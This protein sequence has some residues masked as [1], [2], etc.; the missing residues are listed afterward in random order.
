MSASPLADV[1]RV[2]IVDDQ[3]VYRETARF[4]VEMTD[5]FEVVGV[6]ETGEQ[7]LESADLLQPELVLMD[8]NMPGIDGLEATRRLRRAQPA[9]TVIV[10]STLS[11]REYEP[12]AL[13]AGA[14]AFVAKADLSPDVLTASWHAGKAAPPS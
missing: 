14:V 2:M 9:V 11:R 10:F 1:V 6:A 3:D 8:I 13:E 7:A 5:G 12:R 4:V